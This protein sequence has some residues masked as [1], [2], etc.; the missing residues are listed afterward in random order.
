MEHTSL[1]AYRTAKWQ[2]R[3]ERDRYADSIA[4]RWEILKDPDTRGILLRDAVGDLV[5]NWGPYK[6][7]HDMFH[8]RVSGSAVSSIGSAVSSM[9]PGF[10]K[11]MIFGG[12]SMLLGKVIG[13]E[14]GKH[15]GLLSSISLG[16]GSMAKFLRDRK[17]KRAEAAAEVDA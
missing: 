9:L 11:R 17:E 13:D 7:V 1:N 4:Q 12:L 8:G 6:K 10:K 15:N 16:L 14:P 3:R 5:R 2:I